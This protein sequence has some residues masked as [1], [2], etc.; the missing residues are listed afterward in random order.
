V[1]LDARMRR[2]PTNFVD[3]LASRDQPTD[4]LLVA[5]ELGYM[6]FRWLYTV[7]VDRFPSGDCALLDPPAVYTPDAKGDFTNKAVQDSDGWHMPELSPMVLTMPGHEPWDFLLQPDPA[8]SSQKHWTLRI[9]FK[10]SP[11]PVIR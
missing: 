9:A 1:V 7:D 4:H 3:S 11:A 5:A 2:L 6:K 8:D 10:R